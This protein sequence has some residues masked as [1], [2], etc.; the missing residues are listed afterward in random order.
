MLY[1]Q[2]GH[3]VHIGDVVRVQRDEQKHTSRGTRPRYRDRNGIVVALN[4]REN[5][6]GV[7]WQPNYHRPR[8]PTQGSDR[9]S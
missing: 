5:E 9:T 2:G 1:Q 4:E 6:I 7:S 3:D 8:K